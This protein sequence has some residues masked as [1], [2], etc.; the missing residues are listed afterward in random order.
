MPRG[1]LSCALITPLENRKWTET[2]QTVPGFTS[3]DHHSSFSSFSTFSHYGSSQYSASAIS[4]QLGA[5]LS[6]AKHSFIQHLLNQ[7][8]QLRKRSYLQMTA[9]QKGKSWPLGGVQDKHRGSLDVCAA[10]WRSIQS[11]YKDIN[12]AIV[13]GKWYDG[14]LADKTRAWKKRKTGFFYQGKVLIHR[15]PSE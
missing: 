10:N 7:A 8:S 12:P 9:W 2:F 1:I 5:N 11:L 4:Q 6:G 3:L 13:P 14:N 15:V